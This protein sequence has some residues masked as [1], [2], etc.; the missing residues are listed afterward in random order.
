MTNTFGSIRNRASDR[1]SGSLDASI[2]SF[3]LL[4]RLHL[5]SGDGLVSWWI[6]LQVIPNNMKAINLNARRALLVKCKMRCKNI[7]DRKYKTWYLPNE[8]RII[9][10]VSVIDDGA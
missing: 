1:W 2:S 5:T 7:Y 10:V 9:H 8:R 4:L 6:R 3:L